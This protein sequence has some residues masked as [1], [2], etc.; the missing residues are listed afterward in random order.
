MKI[1]GNYGT[2]RVGAFMKINPL[3]D[4]YWNRQWTVNYIAASGTLT[5][6][7]KLNNDDL[8]AFY[9]KSKCK[10]G[11]VILQLS[12]GD[13]KKE[14]DISNNFDQR[15]E[16]S[17]FNAEEKIKMVL[18]LESVKKIKILIGWRK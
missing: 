4:W 13:I 11:N 17:V 9:I 8:F 14:I 5:K 10:K 2:I 3:A 1:F 12:Q 16:M 18:I 6:Y 7:V 15:I